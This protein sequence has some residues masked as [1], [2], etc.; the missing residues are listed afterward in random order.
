MPDKPIIPSWRE[1]RMA[2][3]RDLSEGT[4]SAGGYLVP[5]D[6]SHTWFPALGQRRV[7]GGPARP[8]D[9][10]RRLHVPKIDTASR[11]AMFAEAALVRRPHRFPVRTLPIARPGWD[12]S[13]RILSTP[14]TKASD[15]LLTSS[16]TPGSGR[17]ARPTAS[18]CCDLCLGGGHEEQTSE[19]FACG[20]EN[21]LMMSA[22]KEID[23]GLLGVMFTCRRCGHRF[24][25]VVVGV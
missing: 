11:P 8:R 9:A 13:A 25:H 18:S 6:H 23:D 17:G 16:G 10:A 24:S 5:P 1:Y 20:A 12:P 14:R 21:A 2:E 3:T 15:L 4:A 7:A 19:G 22:P